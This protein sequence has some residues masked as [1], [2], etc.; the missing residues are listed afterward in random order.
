M[1]QKLNIKGF[2]EVLIAIFNCQRNTSALQHGRVSVAEELFKEKISKE[3]K[4]YREAVQLQE[5]VPCVLR[6]EQKVSA[7]KGA[8]RKFKALGDYK[9]ANAR[10]KAC[11]KKAALICEEGAQAVYED[12]LRRQEEAKTKSEYVDAIA[13]FRRVVR[14]DGYR[15]CAKRNIQL[16]KRKIQHL[17]RIAAWRRRLLALAVL[18]GCAVLFV[19]TPGYPFAKGWIHQ[20]K[21]NYRA[22]IANYKE[23]SAI[24]WTKDLKSS[25]YYKLALE[26]LDEGKKEQAVKLLKKAKNN[27]AARKKLKELEKE[28]AKE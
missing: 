6:F 20:Q 25:C 12:A 27:K 9:D 1:L 13:E 21:G 7:L 5:A 28:L 15:E 2:S 24:S 16:C 14:R 19:Q 23:A 18:A 3:E 26:K 8:A 4:I 11:R 22:A 17:E 10:M